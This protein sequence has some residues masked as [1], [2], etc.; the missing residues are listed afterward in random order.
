VVEYYHIAV[1]RVSW[2]QRKGELAKRWSKTAESREKCRTKI[3]GGGRHIPKGKQTSEMLPRCKVKDS[4]ER[5]EKS[6]KGKKTVPGLGG[7]PGRTEVGH[8]KS[9]N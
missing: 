9:W 5:E 7:I 3:R 1:S 8:N 6:G 2:C 4:D